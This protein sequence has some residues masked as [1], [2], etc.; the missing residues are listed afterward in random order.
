MSFTL[1][2][3]SKDL[4]FLNE[5]LSNKDFLGIDTEFRRKSKD[6]IKLALIQVND[7]D[8][9]ETFPQNNGTNFNDCG[10]A[11]Y[12][13]QG[14]LLRVDGLPPIPGV[15]GSTSGLGLTL[16]YM[17]FGAPAHTPRNLLESCFLSRKHKFKVFS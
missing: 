9:L 13:S 1:I 8:T 12:D 4:D 2:E 5:E 6:H 17:D 3:N 15:S 11:I 14:I 16:L 10:Y 7:G